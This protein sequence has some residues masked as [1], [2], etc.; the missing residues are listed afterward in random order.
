M[1]LDPIR[2]T[3]RSLRCH[4]QKG[5]FNI[6][7][8]GRFESPVRPWTWL[9]QHCVGGERSLFLL[10]QSVS[11]SFII[12]YRT[13]RPISRLA[14]FH[15]TTCSMTGCLGCVCCVPIWNMFQIVMVCQSEKCAFLKHVSDW[16][17]VNF[18]ISKPHVTC[19]VLKKLCEKRPKVRPSCFVCLLVLF[20]FFFWFVFVCLFVCLFVFS[21]NKSRATLNA[22]S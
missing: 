5:R 11:T 6:F 16:H 14:L 2:Y 20:Y 8:H 13:H 10:N 15:W 7:C 3:L 18:V 4:G 9:D 17:K 19:K 21:S 12:V 22:I 1:P